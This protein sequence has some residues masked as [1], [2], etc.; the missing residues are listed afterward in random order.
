MVGG[1][2]AEGRFSGGREN[3][4]FLEGEEGGK[5]VQGEA[6][7]RAEGGRDEQEKE[8]YGAGGF[9]SGFVCKGCADFCNAGRRKLRAGV[10]FLV[11]G[12][13]VFLVD[14]GVDLRAGDV[15]VAEEFLDDAEVGAVFEEVGGEGVA[16]KVGVEVLREAGRLGAG[17]DDLAH[18][19]GGKRAAKD[20]EEEV[21]GGFGFDECGALVGEVVLDGVDGTRADGDESGFVAFSGDAEKGVVQVEV[22]EFGLAEFGKTEAGGVEK[23]EQGEVAAGEVF[24]GVEGG[25]EGGDV[26]RVEGFGEFFAGFGREKRFGGIGGKEVFFEEVAEKNFEVDEVDAEG[27]G[28]ETGFFAGSQEE[29]QFLRAEVFPR[30]VTVFPAPAVELFEGLAHGDLVGGGEAALG[31]EVEDEVLDFLFQSGKG[32]WVRLCLVKKTLARK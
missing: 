8:E 11:D 31:G 13:E 9:Q 19:R 30:V 29:G 7:Q 12:F 22:L 25:E 23:F 17:F 28:I 15:G 2:F 10:E 18:A 1:K 16:Q 32:K 24:G 20:G 21:G 6:G 4:F 3:E 26:L 14:V 5:L 27:G